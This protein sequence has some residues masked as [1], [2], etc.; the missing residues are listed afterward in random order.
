M[1]HKEEA[2]EIDNDVKKISKSIENMHLRPYLET[3]ANPW[4]VM[5]LSFLKGIATGFGTIIGAT[6]LVSLV[7]YILSRL[8]VHFGG[9]PIVGQWLQWIGQQLVKK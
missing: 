9:T 6:I 5:W 8:I 7:I 2:K 4:K 1:D 3:L